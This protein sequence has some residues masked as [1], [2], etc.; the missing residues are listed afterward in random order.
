MIPT[1]MISDS[2]PIYKKNPRNIKI[3]PAFNDMIDS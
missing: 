1:L 3:M 2:P